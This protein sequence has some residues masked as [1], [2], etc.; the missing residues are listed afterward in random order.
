MARDDLPPPAVQDVVAAD[1]QADDG[2]A[3][4]VSWSSYT[5]PQD[6]VGYRV[7]R[8]STAFT[9]VNQATQIAEIRGEP[10][11]TFYLDRTTTDGVNYWY[12]VT[13]F[14]DEG[15]ENAQVTAAG[16]VQSSPNLTL[17]LPAGTLLVSIGAET[18]ERDMAALL[19]IDPAELKLAR[20][21]PYQQAYRTYQANP[22]DSFLQHAPGRAFWVK[23]SRPLMLNVAG[24]RVEQDPFPVPLDPGWNMVGNPFAHDMRW[25]GIKVLSGGTQYTLPESNR[26]GITL[27][28]AWSWDPYTNSYQ[29]VSEYA[30]FGAKSVRQNTGFWFK[31]LRSCD[32]L[33]PSGVGTASVASGTKKIAVDWQMRLVAR[34]GSNADCD[35]YIGVSTEAASLNKLVTPPRPE[36]GLELYFVNTGVDGQAAASFVRP[37]ETQRWIARVQLSGT[38]S[39]EVEISWP[40]LSGVPPDVRPV[41]A[42]EA[43]GKRVYMRTNTAYRFWP[44]RN[45]Q[46]RTFTIEALPRQEVLQVSALAARPTGAGANIV[47]ALSAPA[48]VNVEVLN[49]A[50]RRVRLLTAGRETQ[51]GTCSLYWNGTGDSGAAVPSG[52]Y[53]VRVRARSE[54][55]Q[56]RSQVTTVRLRR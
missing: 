32:L 12:A 19:N 52:T 1:N 23:L 11:R 43:T 54:D 17:S 18:Q 31:A 16:P 25:E 3:I 41:L 21:D 40:D 24:R 56:E 33:L 36:P 8:G 45:E 29:L 50:G 4:S 10:E 20:Y 35:N 42:D 49:I 6:F 30:N 37:S 47:F 28:F 15:N 53:L 5:P 14:D 44:G 34:C 39:D 38:G 51:A 7:Y 48:S 2:G 9:R 55:G 26:V 46:E 27:D 22:N 13:A